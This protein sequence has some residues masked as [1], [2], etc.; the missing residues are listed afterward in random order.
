MKNLVTI[1]LLI[2]VSFVYCQDT[3][4]RTYYIPKSKLG[5]LKVEKTVSFSDL[6]PTQ[7]DSVRKVFKDYKTVEYMKTETINGKKVE[8]KKIETVNEEFFNNQKYT[9]T[10]NPGRKEV[11]R[12]FV[13]FPDDKNQI[14]INPFLNRKDTINSTYYIT[15]K[16]RRTQWLPFTE[17]TVSSLTIPLKYRFGDDSNNIGEE[18]TSGINLNFLLGYSFGNSAFTF[19]DKVGNK[20]NTLKI[21]GCVIL[22]A[23][24]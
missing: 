14:I 4:R 21:T 3:Y 18:F 6:S 9:I 5:L 1:F 10:V 12:A 23:S 2:C 24:T 20:T 22:G 16:N 8:V 19:R 11:I 13:K 7:Q 15:L 17:F